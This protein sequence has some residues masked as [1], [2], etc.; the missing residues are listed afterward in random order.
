MW[1]V[2]RLK[3]PGWDGGSQGDLAL[4]AG[5]KCQHACYKDDFVG[6][7]DHRLSLPWAAPSCCKI[8]C[9][10]SKLADD[11][12]LSGAVDT[13]EGWDVIQRDLDKLE[14]WAYVNFMRFNKAM[15]KVLDLAQGNPRYQH[16]WGDEGMEQPCQEGPGGTGG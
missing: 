14:R 10:L 13:P 6:E 2:A 9:T 7:E 4:W 3:L 5:E 16:R 1:R 11:T 12:R 8:E 15:C